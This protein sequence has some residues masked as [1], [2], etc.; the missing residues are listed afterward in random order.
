MDQAIAQLPDYHVR[1]FDES[2]GIRTV[3]LRRMTKD[4][5]D[6]VWLLY[7]NRVKR[8]DG[9]RIT[10]FFPGEGLTSIFCDP[11]NQV[12]VSSTTT[13]YRFVNDH[14]G[15]RPV[16][17]AAAGPL[18]LGAVFQLPGK[19]VWLLTSEGFFSYEQQSGK[20]RKLKAPFP[21]APFNIRQYSL[22]TYANTLFY[23]SA[24]YVYRN[25]PNKA[26]ID[27]L[28]VTGIYSVNAL[29][30]QQALVTNWKNQSFLYDFSQQKFSRLASGNIC[31]IS[32]T[33]FWRSMMYCTSVRTGICW[34][35]PRD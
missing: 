23:C 8:F 35:A 4:R 16:E 26:L 27:S 1:L 28:P 5:Q 21:G 3:G 17:I 19:P 25:A 33:I 13:L 10:E 24:N 34:Q 7:R 12:W 6:F 2:F 14:T 32:Q 9:K 15:F 31:H 22:S 11:G 20:F 29:N 18:Q 30:E